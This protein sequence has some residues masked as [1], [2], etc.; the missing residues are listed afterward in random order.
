MFSLSSLVF[1]ILVLFVGLLALTVG[2]GDNANEMLEESLPV[3]SQAFKSGSES[4]KTIAV[5]MISLGLDF[6]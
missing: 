3:I 1:N 2:C 6:F 5:S 4:T